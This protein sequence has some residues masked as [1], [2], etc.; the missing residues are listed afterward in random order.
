TPTGSPTAE[1][2]VRP[3]PTTPPTIAAG[4]WKGAGTLLW[5]RRAPAMVALGDGRVL[6]V[7]D[8]GG[9]YEGPPEQSRFAELWNPRTGTWRETESLPAARGR[10][11]IIA[12]RDGRAL[13]AGGWNE[14]FVSYSSAYVYDGRTGRWT[15]TGL[16]GT[17]RTAPAIAVLR[18]GR[19]LVAGGGYFT[20]LRTEA[21]AID[22][23][24]YSGPAVGGADV[25]LADDWPG[26]DGRPLA[27]AELFD[28]AT[29]QWTPTGPMRH[30]IWSGSA[31]TLRD[32]RVLISSVDPSYHPV[33][34]VYDPAAGRFT[35]VAT[36]SAPSPEVLTGLGV[37]SDVVGRLSPSDLGTV[38]ALPN[39]DALFVAT[40]GSASS[41]DDEYSVTRTLRLEPDRQRWSDIGAP[42]VEYGRDVDGRWTVTTRGP[43]H[44]TGIAVALSDGRV[45]LAGGL[46]ASGDPS[47]HAELL[48]PLNAEYVTLPRMPGARVDAVGVALRDGSALV[49]GGWTNG[50]DGWPIALGDTFRFVPAR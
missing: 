15:K 4:R 46:D 47:R 29:G 13:V 17:A 40:R 10:L 39:G 49:A 38:A 6:V 1:P 3:S 26:P 5:P 20:G 27:T 41:G 37:P 23:A 22:L 43:R 32:G 35:T 9:K 21:A 30:A 44:P 8:E 45:L 18:D 42:T 25:R 11:A 24:A 12:L 14:K 28:P 36:P 16:M 50:G 48:D 19:V 2:T 34:E 7:G 33:L 31:V